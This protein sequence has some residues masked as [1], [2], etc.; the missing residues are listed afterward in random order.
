MHLHWGTHTDL[1]AIRGYEVNKI[2]PNL[3]KTGLNS[4]LTP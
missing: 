2:A 3:A 4:I 1:A